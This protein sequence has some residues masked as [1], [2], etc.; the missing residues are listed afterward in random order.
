MRP[1]FDQFAARTLSLRRNF[2]WTFVGN[3]VYAGCQWGMLVILAKLGTPEMVGQFVLGLAVTAPVI[4]FANLALRAVEATDANHEYFF[5]DYFG[6]RLITTVLALLIIMGITFVTGYQWEMKL[7]ILVVGLAK[8]IESISDLFYGLLQQHEWMDRIA[9]SMMIKGPLSLAALGI[10]V[11]LS[12]SVVW[13]VMGVM[14]I[15]ALVLIGYD[16]RSTVLVLKNS[17]QILLEATSGE[18]D[19]MGMMRPRWEMPILARL[20][21]LALP[22]G[23]TAMLIS[24][25]TNIPRY[26]IE[27]YLGER[28]LGIFASMAYLIKAGGMVVTSL[29]QSATPRLAKHYAAGNGVAFRALLLKLMGIGTLLGVVALLIVLLAGKEI[30]TLLYRPEYGEHVDVLMWLMVAGAISYVSSFLG[31]G[32]TASR[33]FRIQP[34]IFSVCV[35]LAT[36][37]SILLIPDHGI[38][39]AAWVAVI[40]GCARITQVF[41]CNLYA[42][43]ALNKQGVSVSRKKGVIQ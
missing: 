22:L 41:L 42:I 32:M 39:G 13:G 19:Q 25:N 30:L 33:Y 43:H 7:V 18:E 12:G 1:Q 17:P 35:L 29:G 37:F 14:V 24:L 3:G 15:W 34:V 8:A 31:Y 16:V 20:A 21:W 11:Y 23:F 26:F 28:E 38:L 9:K 2:S 6:L 27:H 4:I 5:G 36:V 40:V 10:G